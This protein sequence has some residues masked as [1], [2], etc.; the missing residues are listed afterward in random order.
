MILGVIKSLKISLSNHGLIPLR[1]GNDFKCDHIIVNLRT[2]C[3]ASFSNISPHLHCLLIY[4]LLQLWIKVYHSWKGSIEI[5]SARSLP[6][7]G[8]T[9]DNHIYKSTRAKLARE[10]YICFW[11]ILKQTIGITVCCVFVQFHNSYIFEILTNSAFTP[12]G[13]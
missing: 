3:V 2:R 7:F 1:K 9:R 6:N 5:A 11:H 8:P 13:K 10:N 4:S 12:F